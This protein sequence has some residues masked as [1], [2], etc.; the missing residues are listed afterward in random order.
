MMGPQ[1]VEPSSFEN[2]HQETP[3][4]RVHLNLAVTLEPD[5]NERAQEVG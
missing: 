1:Q 2:V 3:L 4:R 5:G